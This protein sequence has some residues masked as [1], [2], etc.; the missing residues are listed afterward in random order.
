MSDN[1]SSDFIRLD[2]QNVEDYP[3]WAQIVEFLEVNGMIPYE[4][5]I[6]PW[7]G[8]PATILFYDDDDQAA[9]AAQAMSNRWGQVRVNDSYARQRPYSVVYS[10]YA[11]HVWVS[12]VE[13]PPLDTLRERSLALLRQAQSRLR[14]DL[15]GLNH[16]ASATA[17]GDGWAKRAAERDTVLNLVVEIDTLLREMDRE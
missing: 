9:T 4:A 17:I 12:V 11:D 13:D 15:V 7:E 6:V 1:M 14:L 3:T 5:H 10:H 8:M 2:Q 16:E